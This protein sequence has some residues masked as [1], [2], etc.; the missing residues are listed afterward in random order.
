MAQL[1][2]FCGLIKPPSAGTGAR[3]KQKKELVLLPPTEATARRRFGATGVVLIEAASQAVPKAEIHPALFLFWR[4]RHDR[5]P[6]SSPLA[7]SGPGKRE[8]YCRG[9]AHRG[10]QRGVA[11]PPIHYSYC[12]SVVASDFAVGAA[13]VA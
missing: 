4:R 12:W 11:D 10:R 3:P 13:V 8:S 7:R 6:G 5:H 1:I 9:A 2:F